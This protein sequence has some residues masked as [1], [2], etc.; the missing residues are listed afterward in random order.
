MLQWCAGTVLMYLC[1]PIIVYSWPITFYVSGAIGIVWVCHVACPKA[2]HVSL[3]S[4]QF[5]A[6]MYYGTS[7]PVDHRFITARERAYILR[8]RNGT[9]INLPAS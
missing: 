3:C 8:E 4:L 9:G 5:F 1:S 7:D 6:S 2:P